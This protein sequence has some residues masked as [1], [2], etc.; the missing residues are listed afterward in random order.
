MKEIKL[1]IFNYIH[2]FCYIITTLRKFYIKFSHLVSLGMYGIPCIYLFQIITII[3][4]I[5]YVQTVKLD[6]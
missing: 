5:L 3:I 4:C 2:P 1:D 6:E